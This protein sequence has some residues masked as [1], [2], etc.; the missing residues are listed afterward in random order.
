MLL[1]DIQEDYMYMYMCVY[2]HIYMLIIRLKLII[3]VKSNNIH[4]YTLCV[5]ILFS[6]GRVCEGIVEEEIRDVVNNIL[7]DRHYQFERFVKV[8]KSHF[9]IDAY[10]WYIEKNQCINESEDFSFGWLVIWLD[11][12]VW[13]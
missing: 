12:T 13:L 2:T 7:A 4:T 1:S 9:N 6:V 5:C 3:Q 10:E 8:F 11:L